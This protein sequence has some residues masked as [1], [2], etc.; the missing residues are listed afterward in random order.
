[1]GNRIAQVVMTVY[2]YQYDIHNFFFDW[3]DDWK[4]KVK[5]CFVG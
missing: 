3:S 1:M 2:L 4:I 5:Q